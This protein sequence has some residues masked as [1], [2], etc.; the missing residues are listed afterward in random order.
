MTDKNKICT[1]VEQSNKFIELG[2]DVN[3]ADMRWE[4]ESVD[5]NRKIPIQYEERP[6]V[7]FLKPYLPAWSLSALMGLL[8]Y[9]IVDKETGHSL[10]LEMNKCDDEYHLYY[11]D[12]W[13]F[14]SDIETDFYDDFVDACV[15][16]IIQLKEKDLL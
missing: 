11:Y 12:K 16:L 10:C 13:E 7:G 2:I 3:T 4:A 6:K 14:V 9:E 15:D 5:F 8:K 1:T